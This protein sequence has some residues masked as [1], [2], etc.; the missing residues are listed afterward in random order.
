MSR[1]LRPLK[2]T[3]PGDDA[4]VVGAATGAGDERGGEAKKK[5]TNRIVTIIIR[6][7]RARALKMYPE[8]ITRSWIHHM[9][10]AGTR[11]SH[12]RVNECSRLVPSTA[13]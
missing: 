6:S 3:V 4:A 9:L 5:R 11:H 8:D 12:F 1:D 10:S 7:A 2:I 13:P